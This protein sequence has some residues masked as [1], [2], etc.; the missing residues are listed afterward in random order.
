MAREF[1]AIDHEGE[2]TVETRAPIFIQILKEKIELRERR[3]VR[4]E[5]CSCTL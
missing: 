3:R 2:I 4:N 5:H 1:L